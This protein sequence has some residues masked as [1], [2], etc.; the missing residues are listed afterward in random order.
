MNEQQPDTQP[1]GEANR[2][3]VVFAPRITP[4]LRKQIEGIRKLTAQTINDLGTETLTDWGAKKLGNEDLRNAALAE[5][6]AEEQRLRERRNT[7]TNIFGR[8]ASQT[9]A[10]VAPPKRAEDSPPRSSKKAS[11]LPTHSDR[12]PLPGHICPPSH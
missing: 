3:P 5:I 2:D 9:T 12:L 11:L 1:P 10:E 6:D 4:E 8:T 7:I